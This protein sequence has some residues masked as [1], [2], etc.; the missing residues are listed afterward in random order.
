MAKKKAKKT[1]K[2]ASASP[3]TIVLPEGMSASDRA[4]LEGVAGLFKAVNLDVSQITFVNAGDLSP[5]ALNEVQDALQP[6]I[7][8]C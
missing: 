5:G 2:R 8:S 6:I 4:V 7:V 3:I 1:T